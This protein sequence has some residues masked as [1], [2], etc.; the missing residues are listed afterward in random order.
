MNQN[1]VITKI[2]WSNVDI[3]PERF[4]FPPGYFVFAIW[5]SPV[6][7]DAC[8][9]NAGFSSFANT[10]EKWDAEFKVI[11]QQLLEALVSCGELVIRQD[12]ECN[13]VYSFR[14]KI[15]L[16][17][18]LMNPVVDLNLSERILLAATDSQF[19]DLV[20]DFGSSALAAIRVGSG[21]PI[22]WLGIHQNEKELF[23]KCLS[24]IEEGRYVENLKLDWERLI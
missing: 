5:P 4:G 2:Q 17:L 16:S 24:S 3:S 11:I 20:I 22:F 7:P 1:K 19:G 10:D 12:I 21:H 13:Y 8:F 6:E 18:K 15:L 14:E 9:L 23:L